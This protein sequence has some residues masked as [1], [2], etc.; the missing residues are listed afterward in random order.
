MVVSAV[1]TT[2]VSRATISEATEVRASAQLRRDRFI[3]TETGGPS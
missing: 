3:S 2:S 1:D